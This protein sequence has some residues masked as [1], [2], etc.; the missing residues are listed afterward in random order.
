MGGVGKL[1]YMFRITRSDEGEHRVC[2][3][4]YGGEWR[5]SWDRRLLKAAW[6]GPELPESRRDGWGNVI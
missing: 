6:L 3:C 5:S 4:V 2:V 1:I